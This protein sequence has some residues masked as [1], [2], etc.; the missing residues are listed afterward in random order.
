V[1]EVPEIGGY[2]N[3]WDL[4]EENDGEEKGDDGNW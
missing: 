3:P 4:K 1:G 2:R